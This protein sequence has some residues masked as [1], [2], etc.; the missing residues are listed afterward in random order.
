M[1]HIN[2]HLSNGDF[3]STEMYDEVDS[4]SQRMHMVE[5]A[6]KNHEIIRGIYTTSLGAMRNANIL[7]SK[8]KVVVI[9]CAH[10]NGKDTHE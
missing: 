4:L 8:K 6:I 9:T 3:I 5:N 10:S 2:I 1:P 7:I